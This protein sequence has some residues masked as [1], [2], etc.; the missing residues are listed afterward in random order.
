MG[1]LVAVSGG[2]SNMLHPDYSTDDQKE[3]ET[4]QSEEIAVTEI[5]TTAA[6]EP[7]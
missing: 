6:A 2:G 1:A 4:S 7:Q 5:A 3:V